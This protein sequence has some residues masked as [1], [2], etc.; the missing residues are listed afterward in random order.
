LLA[1]LG[2]ENG[3]RLERVNGASVA[4]PE[5]ALNAYTSMRYAQ[6]FDVEVNRAGRPVHIEIRV[7]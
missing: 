1:A 4:T 3:D 5:G 7:N 6:Q 2:I